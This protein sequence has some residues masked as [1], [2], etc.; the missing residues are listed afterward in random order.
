MK[1]RSKVLA[2]YKSLKEQCESLINN[3]N[4]GLNS[5]LKKNEKPT[6]AHVGDLHFIKD[7]LEGISKFI[8]L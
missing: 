4:Q 7:Q 3:I 2:E 5:H 8:N 6:Y 1:N